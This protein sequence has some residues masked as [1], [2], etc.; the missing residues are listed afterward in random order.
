MVKIP[1]RGKPPFLKAHHVEDGD[2]ATIIEPPYILD[3]EKS[4]FGKERTIITVKLRRDEQ[5]YRWGLNTT[6]NDRLVE[7]FGSEGDLWKSKEVRIQKR[8]EIVRGE[9]KHVLYALPSIQQ[10][11]AP[12]EKPIASATT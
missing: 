3:A 10:S 9:E 12:P 5:L 4:T 2:L 8:S 6:S 1:R 7:K 11:I